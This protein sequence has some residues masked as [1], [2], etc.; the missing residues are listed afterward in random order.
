MQ[1]VAPEEQRDSQYSGYCSAVVVAVD[2]DVVACFGLLLLYA[3]DMASY[4]HTQPK[5]NLVNISGSI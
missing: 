2:A 4:T 5:L 3:I 1:K